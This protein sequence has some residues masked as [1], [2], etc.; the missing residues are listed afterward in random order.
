VHDLPRSGIVLLENTRFNAGDEENK[1]AFARAL[2]ANADIF[3]LESFGTAHRRHASIVGVARFLPAYA[4]LRF[5]K[6]VDVLSRLIAHP[7]H[8]TVAILGGAKISTKLGLI[9]RLLKRYD[10]LLL[11]GALANVVL[12]AKGI[13]IGASLVEPNVLNLVRDLDLANPHLHIPID[14]IVRGSGAYATLRPV[15]R[16]RKGE[17]IVDIGPDTVELFAAIIRRAGTVIWNG[18]MGIYEER[19]FDRGTLALARTVAAS[20]AFSVVGG[21]ETVDAVRHEHLEQ[22]MNFISTGGGAMMEFLEGKR[23][24]GVEVVKIR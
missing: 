3:V 15:G 18:P 13:Q 1:P 10:A 20:S 9:T 14:V 17:A 4:G 6:E 8:P 24:P 7:R 22:K 11:G 2:A 23:L 19:P 21:G 12:K 5:V 16:V